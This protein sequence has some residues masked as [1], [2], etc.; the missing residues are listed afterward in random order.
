MLSVLRSN[1]RTSCR[2]QQ[3]LQDIQKTQY[4]W[5]LAQ[6]LLLTDSPNCQFF[7]A[8]TYTVKINN[9]K[10]TTSESK[11]PIEILHEL[12]SS[13]ILLNA[14][15]N[16]QTHVLR[17]VLS[18]LSRFFTRFPDHWHE[19]IASTISVI[20][21]GKPLPEKYS[22]ET[23]CRELTERKTILCLE[24]CQV[25]I[26][27]V[28][29]SN[30]EFSEESNQIDAIINK[31]IPH[32]AILLRYASEVLYPLSC[33]LP[34]LESTVKTYGAWAL[35]HPMGLEHRHHLHPVTN[36]IFHSIEA[37]P[38]SELYHVALD[39]ISEILNRFPSFYDD[40]TKSRL[41]HILVETGRPMIAQIQKKISQIADSS[42]PYVYDDDDI[43]DLY[44]RALSFSKVTMAVCELAMEDIDNITSP[45]ISALFDYLLVMSNFPGFPYVDHN[46][47]TF[48]LEFWGTY[49]DAFLDTD[50]SINLGDANPCII[51]AIEIFWNKSTLPYPSEHVSWRADSWEAFAQFR[52]DFWAF[53]DSTYVLVGHPL[54]NTFVSNVLEQ[55]DANPPNWEKL[56][57]SLSC[58]NALSANI[59]EASH[60]YTLVAQLFQSPLLE[61]LS[62]LDNM[63]IRTTGVNFIGSYDSFFE[64]DIGKPFL[65][66]ALDYLFKSLPTA[67]LSNTASRSIQK[68]CSSSRAFLSDS[69]ASFF[70][71]YTGM[72]LYAVLSNTAHERTVL[73]IACVIQ[74]VEDLEKKGAYINHLITLILAQLEKVYLEYDE[75]THSSNGGTPST[76]RF[77]RIVS[78]LNCLASIGQGLQVPEGTQEHG[79]IQ[80]IKLFWD[81]DKF[82]IRTHLLEVMRIFSLER[83]EFKSNLETC[84]CCCAILQAGFS[85][86]YG[87]YV[88]PIETELEF[89]KAKYAVGPK[90]CFSSLIDLASAFL[91]F[92][93]EIPVTYIHSLL[94]TFF[95]E[96][97]FLMSYEP[98]TQASY[99]QLLRQIILHYPNALL[100]HPKIKMIIN[101][102]AQML[103]TTEQVSLR[104]AT[105]F[106]SAFLSLTDHHIKQQAVLA[107][108][109]PDLAE[110]LVSKISGHCL[111]SELE[112]YTEVIK[113][114]LTHTQVADAWFRAAIVESP[115]DLVTA[116]VDSACRQ[117][118]FNDLMCHRGSKETTLVI[119]QF[120]VVSHSH[121]GLTEQN[122]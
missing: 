83:S 96:L 121:S 3:H 76:E 66:L 46:L 90:E 59:T 36:F 78:L 99:L 51:K 116:Q 93:S 57:V 67:A 28:K 10:N 82:H 91:T 48:L 109:G 74:A 44:E 41:A 38:D 89:I 113:V 30:L 18:S 58:I 39:E 108:I 7:G 21:T 122:L 43:E 11:T 56:E 15:P 114:L 104:E 26:E 117:Q 50:D 103:K 22:L 64:D 32:L 34:I 42:G 12:L 45:Q 60:E 13:L 97:D 16:V 71:S 1:R 20:A 80:A 86:P 33:H 75:S 77:T 19:C 84:Q 115:K 14:K 69:L 118:L 5:Q 120:W 62:H 105:F 119:R 79:D 87:L 40:H 61:K 63:H 73:A 49:A 72:S 101:F 100:V 98:D 53:L 110:T 24:F 9:Y 31:N 81:A 4:G 27:D 95:Q 102:A 23:L 35:N 52:K 17:K 112:F 94:E 107:T 47:A 88:F 111:R 2:T 68:L 106:W 37:N 54:F 70:E 25:L 85:Q 92:K 8:L 29:N 65:F 55:L 6:D